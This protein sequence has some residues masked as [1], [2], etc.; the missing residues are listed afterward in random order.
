MPN[1]RIQSIERAVTILN[2][3][4]SLDKELTTMEISQLIDLPQSSTY[5]FLMTLLSLKLVEQNKITNKFRLGVEC[6]A[7]GEAFQRQNL[8]REKA[9]D[10]LVVLRDICGETIHLAIKDG[11][12]GVYLEKLAGLHPIGMMSSRIGANF[13]LYSTGIGKSLLANLN[14]KELQDYLETNKLF[15]KTPNTITQPDI[16]LKELE[17]IREQGYS[18]DN[19]ENE[20][21]VVCVGSPIFDNFSCRGALSAS[22]PA[23]RIYQQIKKGNLVEQII[24]TSR[25]ISSRMGA[26][27]KT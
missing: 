24:K 25:E 15:S 12:H 14:Q 10:S 26:I 23:D 16:L 22:G 5:R 11:N 4:V 19:E 13:I 21:G 20:V 9:I 7:L 3:L 17:R 8:L 6:L 27:I 18:I 1:Y 2:I